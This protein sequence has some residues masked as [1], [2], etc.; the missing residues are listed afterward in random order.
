M[1]IAAVNDRV[2][3]PR[4]NPARLYWRCILSIGEHRS[5]VTFDHPAS[6]PRLESSPPASLNERGFWSFL[7]A[8]AVSILGDRFNELV[9]PILVLNATNSAFL[10]GLVGAANRLP[11][12]LF[13]VW[14]VCW[15]IARPNGD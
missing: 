4:N 11:A 1:R 8:R 6:A 7:L 12:L 15:S 5:A 13:A 10:A 9:I 2:L 3:R 14:I